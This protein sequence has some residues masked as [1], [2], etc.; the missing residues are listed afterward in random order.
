MGTDRSLPPEWDALLSRL[1]AADLPLVHGALL[2]RFPVQYSRL[3]GQLF[4]SPAL[5]GQGRLCADDLIRA[6]RFARR[7]LKAD[8]FYFC[9]DCLDEAA[10]GA[11]AP[12]LPPE[13]ARA[14][15]AFLAEND[16]TIV[17]TPAVIA[18]EAAL[19]ILACNSDERLVSFLEAALERRVAYFMPQVTHPA[20]RYFERNDA[21]RRV[22]TDES[23]LKLKKFDL[24]DFEN[25]IQALEL[26]RGLPGAYVEIGVYQGRSARVALGY[27][28]ERGPQ[29]ATFLLDTYAGFHYE[30]AS[31]SPDV[32]WSGRHGDAGLDAVRENLGEFEAARLV[33]A[34]IITDDLPP[35]TEQI[36]LAN[37]DVD[38][39]EA[40]EAALEKLS[41]RVV[42]GG[43]II[44]EDQ[45]HTPLLGGAYVATQRFLKRHVEFRGIHLASGQMFL[46]KSQS[47]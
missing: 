3:C 23:R 35:G 13:D 46:L 27:M 12:A 30:A 14:V 39:F 18:P 8:R 25:I 1:E 26:T 38:M 6:I 44:A 16:V 22:L 47:P 43:I 45:G 10:T 5:L 31:A 4:H 21:A 17:T 9:S 41:S 20:A 34:N 32:Y 7:N 24:G 19:V 37:V 29:R 11:A 40:I 28:R 36:A 42:P 15:R 33:R 2:E